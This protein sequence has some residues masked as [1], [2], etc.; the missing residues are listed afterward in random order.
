MYHPLSL[1]GYSKIIN[2]VKRQRNLGLAVG[3][4]KQF[5]VNLLIGSCN[6][7]MGATHGP[8]TTYHSGAT[9][10]IPSFSGV[11]VARSLLL[12]VVCYRSLFFIFSFFMWTDGQKDGRTEGRTDRRTDGQKDRQTEGRTDGQKDGQTDRRTDRR[13]EGRT[14]G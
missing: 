1:N 14:D 11:R 2:A 4:Q 7:T 10:F 8:E 3:Y 6:N 13:T 9:E 5:P 12:C